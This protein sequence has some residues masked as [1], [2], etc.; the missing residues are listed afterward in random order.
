MKNI[1]AGIDCN[2]W[3]VIYTKKWTR[4]FYRL[5]ANV[6]SYSSDIAEET[7]QGA[8]QELAIKIESLQTTPRTYYK[9]KFILNNYL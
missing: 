2:D 5:L 7:M 6:P 4:D 8:R 9:F 3:E 1:S